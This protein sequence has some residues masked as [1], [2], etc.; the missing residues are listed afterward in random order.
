MLALQASTSFLPPLHPTCPPVQWTAATRKTWRRNGRFRMLPC[1]RETRQN[2]DPRQIWA[3]ASQEGLT[4]YDERP[5]LDWLLWTEPRL[6]SR[7]HACYAGCLALNLIGAGHQQCDVRCIQRVE[8]KT[9]PW[10]PRD[11]KRYAFIRSTR[12]R[13]MFGTAHRLRF[14]FLSLSLQKESVL[15][16]NTTA[17][18]CSHCAVSCLGNNSNKLTVSAIRGPWP[19]HASLSC[20]K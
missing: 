11:P 14:F 10:R 20:S 19:Q 4:S 13:Q 5:R 1:A 16:N 15:S 18:L 8:K 7:L 17:L 2:S 12:C 9:R 3:R 6:S